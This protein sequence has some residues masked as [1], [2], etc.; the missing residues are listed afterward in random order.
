VSIEAEQ[1]RPGG[2]AHRTGGALVSGATGSVG[3][4]V[5][6]LLADRGASVTA[7]YRSSHDVASGL[8][9]ELRARGTDAV[10]QSVD[11][12]DPAAVR[13]AVTAA[14]D[15]HGGLH[16]LVHAA[17]PHVPQRYL[18]TVTPDEYAAQLSEE[19]AAFFNLAHPA[20]P[21]LRESHGCIVAVTTVAVRRL[22]RR[23]GLSPGTK[24]SIE[25][26]VR[27]IAAE[28][29]PKGVRAN[30]VGPGILEDGLAAKLRESGDFTDRDAEYALRAIPLRRFGCAAD[31]AEAVC[32]LASPGASYI[33]GQTIDVDGGYSV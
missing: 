18:S 14:V 5:C 26:V 6:R 7:L 4:A 12:T 20:I 13:E 22:P 32:F 3:S 1:P 33:T 10:A 11:L 23:D 31:V 28:E 25:A 30:C 16:T 15:R 29:G 19:A 2:F 17:G 27:V 24:A 9:D 21:A 8:V